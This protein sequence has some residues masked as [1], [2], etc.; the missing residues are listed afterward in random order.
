MRTFKRQSHSGSAVFRAALVVSVLVVAMLLGTAATAS[1]GVISNWTSTQPVGTVGTN[2]PVIVKGTG[3]YD[4]RPLQASSLKLYV[5]GT[6]VPRFLY[7]GSVLSTSV[8]VYY[9]PAVKF[10]DGLRTFRVEVSDSAG[11]L[12]FRQWTATI[13]QPPTAAWTAP[14]AGATLANGSPVIG[15][16]LAD[17]TPGVALSVV[18]E[19]HQGSAT[20]PVVAT[21]GGSG[22]SE[23]IA[24][25]QLPAELPVGIYY[26]TATITDAG[27]NVR[28][29]AGTSARQFRTEAPPAMTGLETCDSCHPS[30]A[31][32]HPTPAS[33]DCTVC[34]AGY[35]GDHM[36]GTESCEDC[37][38][39]GWHT[40]NAKTSVVVTSPCTS[41][42]AAARAEVVQHTPTNVEPSHAGSCG[43]CH[44][45]SIVARHA[46]TPDGSAYAYQC[47]VCHASTDPVVVAA[48]ASGNSGCDACHVGG[49]VGQHETTVPAA[50]AG[51][52]CHS[53]T[54]LSPI[55]AD[56]C[57][58]CHDSTDPDVVLA[59]ATANTE[60]GACH[61]SQGVDYHTQMAT[62]HASATTVSCFGAGCHDSSRDLPA[63]HD[64]YAGPGTVNPEYSDECRLC[65]SNPAVDVTTSGTNCTPACHSGTTHSGYA[66]GHTIT[67]ASVDCT[68]CHASN[69]AGIHGFTGSNWERCDACHLDPATGLATAD[70]SSCHNDPGV[71][72]HSGFA[73]AH[74]YDA[75]EAT[76]QQA[77]CH[78]ASLVDSHA[79]FVGTGGR[80]PQYA[81]TCELCHLNEVVE[82]VPVDATAACSSCHPVADHEAQHEVTLAAECAGCH[83]DAN[84]L[85]YHELLACSTCHES[86]DPAVVAAISGS[87]KRCE[88]CHGAA[89]HGDLTAA[90]AATVTS[91][92]VDVF[93]PGSHYSAGSWDVECT[94]CHASTNLLGAHADDCATCH[95]GSKPADSFT[96]WNRSCSQGS[97]HVGL[98]H[99][100][101]GAHNAFM[102]DC[103][104]CHDSDTWYVDFAACDGCHNPAS[105]APSTTSNVQPSY[106]GAATI[107]FSAS[108]FSF[109][110][111]RLD[112][113]AKV[114][115]TTLVVPPPASGSQAHTVEFWSVG[116]SGLVEAPHK[117]ATFTVAAD[118]QPPVTTS[119]ALG[120]Y[121]G[122]TTITLTVTDN[123][124][125]PV[126]GTYWRLDGGATVAGTTIAIAQPASGQQSRQLEFWSVDSSG[127]EELPHQWANFTVTAD[128]TAPSGSLSIKTGAVYTTTQ[129][130]TLGMS[131]TD[132]DGSGVSQ[133]RFSNDAVNWSAW[134]AYAL[135]KSNYYL[136]AGMGLKTVWVQYRDVAGNVGT[137]SD[138]ITYDGSG[139]GGSIAIN[140]GAASTSS[141]AVTINMSITDTVSGLA[142]MRFSNENTSNWSAW[143]PFSATKAWTL[144]AGTGTRRVYAQFSDNAGNISTTNDVI[145]VAFV[146]STPPT[147]SVSISGGA[148]Y[149][150]T[151]AVTLTLSATDTG[152]SGLSQMQFSTDNVSWSAWETYATSK[153][154]T[155]AAGDGVKTVYARF[156]DV[157]TNVS[158]TYSDTITLDGTL[159]TG[160]ITVDGGA[161]NTPDAAVDLTLSASDGGSGVSQMQFSN[162]GLAWSTWEAYSASKSWT[163]LAGDGIKIVYVRYRDGAGNVSTAYSDTITLGAPE[164]IPPTGSIVINGNAATASMQAVT[165]TLAATDTG[166]SGLSQMQFSNDNV[167]WSAW[168]GYSTS[169]NWSLSSGDGAKTVYVRFRD[170]AGNVS[171][172]YSDGITLAQATATLAFE[173]WSYGEADL[174]VEDAAGNTIASTFVSTALGDDLSWYVTVPAGQRYYM[175]CDWYD[176]WEY[177]SSG[178]GYG[179]WSDD[180]TINPD[181]ILSPNETVVWNY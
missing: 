88:A 68:D 181:G 27:G 46:V 5:D 92:L 41:C 81:D 121:V 67:S 163:L 95:A 150:T 78:S 106:V 53:G 14:V 66:A 61:S 123:A 22:L 162:D 1:A 37:H 18:G 64:I 76:C 50:C 102:Y 51:S 103:E 128:N 168:E 45:E 94:L 75:M 96:T 26:L 130:V 118:T 165:L 31:Q 97:C 25:F 15:M 12:S 62:A 30:I 120:A 108:S 84:L 122:P 154:W 138:T 171:E 58:G 19:V 144:A 156:R 115:S 180:P 43:G 109:T 172:V 107:Q 160:S 176:D 90:H 74:T 47:D 174:H 139:P 17:N 6:L 63:V 112:G 159:P 56:D 36:E 85:P 147:G 93:T 173:W 177:G 141:S 148:A 24:S 113:G 126:Q 10:A 135:S 124:S 134:E 48:I 77:G 142:S 140:G 129:Y 133:M 2:I 72:Y 179:K 65:H 71:D 11:R 38:W 32:A 49:H 178:G 136:S 29:L 99:S 157:A 100:G 40:G 166:G 87:D 111:Y 69:L 98:D 9:T 155:L 101:D 73:P 89:P 82:R 55:H 21:F 169:A 33:T 132:V 80:Y 170:G 8:Y 158:V 110:F 35:D 117:T 4:G 137:F 7:T 28:S 57:A 119:N 146:D 59:I 167:N 39:D 54:N 152:G 70:C 13:A 83:T 44:A 164:T 52:G 151:T 16:Q 116:D 143:E 20:G 127:L 131:A 60:C 104:S 42:H 86:T 161:A 105:E 3:A 175:V 114:A 91:G 23:G 125:S 34:H 149:S 79:A 153:N 145:T